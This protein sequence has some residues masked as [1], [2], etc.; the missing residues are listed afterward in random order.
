VGTKSKPTRLVMAMTLARRMGLLLGAIGMF[1]LPCA[2]AD[3][4]Y[5]AQNGQ[6]P[7]GA[8]NSWATAASNIQDAVNAAST[9]DTVWVGAGR[10][11]LPT[12]PVVFIGT[13][14]VYIDKPLTLRSSNSVPATT[15]IDGSGAYRGVAV[16]YSSHTTNRFAID[17]F[18]ISNCCATNWGGGVLFRTTGLEGQDWNW[19]KVWTGM[20]QNCVISDNTAGPQSGVKSYGGGI[21]SYSYSAVYGLV[22]SNCVIRNNRALHGGTNGPAE[23]GYG[24]G[25]WCR[26]AGGELRM[27][28]C[29]I[30][31]NTANVGGG[32]Y[33][34][35]GGTSIVETCSFMANRAVTSGAANVQNTIFGGG[36]AFNSGKKQIFRDDLF[37]GNS[38]YGSGGGF[39]A[40]AAAADILNCTVVSNA[41][42]GTENYGGAGIIIAHSA[43]GTDPMHTEVCNSIIYSNAGNRD[44]F[45]LVYAASYTNMFFTNCCL[46]ST[47]NVGTLA[48]YKTNVLGS[49]NFTNNPMFADWA[50]QNFRLVNASPC[51]NTGTNQLWMIGA[52]DLDGLP[53]IS[54]KGNGTVDRGAYEF[55]IQYGTILSV[56]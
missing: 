11:T 40:T 46:T 29:R 21:Y 56:R 9:N 12:N 39:S 44:I 45:E 19:S 13:N 3:D 18:A 43:G 33:S 20:V 6:A 51:L 4:H 42:N 7:G 34:E 49:G 50:G 52:V 26:A 47:T 55:T 41:L 36:A 17:G 38:A 30:E 27:T 22:V 14:V 32:L 8:Y 24:G 1:V 15:I 23:F 25:L 54:P 5:A 28:R 2:L 53:R 16:Y 35:A 31:S 48:A 37:W 10:Y